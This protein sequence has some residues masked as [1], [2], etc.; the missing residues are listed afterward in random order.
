MKRSLSDK[1]RKALSDNMTK[2]N[3][4]RKIDLT[5]EMLRKYYID[6]GLTI[7]QIVEKYGYSSSTVTRRLKEFNIKLSK[8]EKSK[9]YSLAGGRHEIF[10]KEEL[11]DL[12]IIQNKTINE[13]CIELN[14]SRS[15]LLRLFKSLNI[16]KPKNL[17][18]ENRKKT[19]IEKY[20]AP[21]AFQSKE[22]RTKIESTN[23]ERYG[24]KNPYASKNIREKIKKVNLERYGVEN[25]WSKGSPILDK[26]KDTNINKY[27]VDNPAKTDEIKQTISSKNKLKASEALINRHKTNLERYGVENI[28]ELD[29]INDKIKQTNLERYG[30]ESPFQSDEVREKIK[31]TNLEK[32]GVEN[33][34]SSNEVKEKIKQTNYERYGVP[35]TLQADEVK[36]RIRQ[37]NLERYGVEYYCETEHAREN[38]KPYKISKINKEFSDRLTSLNINN[39][40]EFSI[41]HKSY[42]IKVDNTLIEIDPTFTHNTSLPAFSNEHISIDYHLNKTKLANENGFNCIHVFDW[43]DKDKIINMFLPKSI[44]YARQ[45]EVKEISLKEANDFLNL[46]HLQ[47]GLMKQDICLGLFYNDN[48]V[49]VM[50]FGKPRYNKNYDYELLRLCT[51]KDYKVTGGTKKLFKYFLDNYKP[52]SIISYCDKSK[53]SGE[54]YTRLGFTLKG[55]AKP[56]R[57]WYNIKEE[58]HI[59]DNLLRQRGFDQLFGT[60]YGKGTSNDELMLEH[61]FVEVYDCGQSTYIWNS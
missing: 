16:K 7:K 35:Y 45:C 41:G 5:E 22:L 19:M 61:N 10:T 33:V 40:L 56:S 34:L 17:E 47:N 27:G 13:L 25:V 6:E 36:E 58:K 1:G 20:G 44:L 15:Y 51:H 2:Q 12:Y 37:T 4:L 26:I 32:Y 46:Y 30:A 38:N 29:E 57:H 55:E 28:R 50:T 11:E 39:D 60:N 59:T 48:L 14:V 8:E 31:K 24:A 54:V 21:T 49:E 3:K 52:N 23:L 18:I 42:D 9:R 43:D 53:F